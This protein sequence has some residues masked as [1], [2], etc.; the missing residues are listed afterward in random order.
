[1]NRAIGIVLMV[2]TLGLAACDDSPTD[3]TDETITFT[4]QL[5]P[6]NEVPPVA[7]AE[8]TGSGT[9][10]I[11]FEI[12]RDSAGVMTDA[13]VNFQVNLAGFP[14]NTPL[15]MAHIH[16]GA[17]GTNGGILVDTGL[18]AGEVTLATG[19]GSFTRNDIGNSGTNGLTLA[20]TQDIIANPGNFYFNVHSVLNPGGMARGQLVRQ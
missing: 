6:A 20:E 11:V 12:D 17:A 10:T 1:M 4:A 18:M 16:T 7:N 9:A 15:T 14:A 2:S 3:P 19:A 13:V 5:S 8:S